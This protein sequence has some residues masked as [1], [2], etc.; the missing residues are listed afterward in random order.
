M[1]IA[2]FVISVTIAVI[3]S[4]GYPGIF[5][6]MLLEGMLLPVPSEVVMLFGGYLTVNGGLEGLLGIQ[7]FVWLLFSGTAGNVTGA[8]IAY[9]IGRYGGVPLLI[10]YGKYI[11]I[12]EKSIL[13]AHSF[14]LKYGGRSVFGTR[15]VP[16]FRT[17]ISIPAGIA[18]MN[19][20]LFVAYTGG[21]TLIWNILLAYLGMLLGK[22]W[23]AVVPY[24]DYL[25]YIAL[26]AIGILAILWA[27]SL[28]AKYRILHA[29]KSA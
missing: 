22:N 23:T 24:F 13:K 12:D 20:P 26:V 28:R 6:L 29:R 3:R 15:L 5:L 7:A 11:L 16:I 27:R 2:G 14:F 9:Y 19:F 8:V 10:R 25:T 4:I 1:S 17:F 21:G 18:Q